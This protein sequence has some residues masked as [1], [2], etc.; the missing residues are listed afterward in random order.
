MYSHPLFNSSWGMG[1]KV[2]H[3][4]LRECLGVF[5]IYFI[6]FVVARLSHAGRTDINCCLVGSWFLSLLQDEHATTPALVVW[7]SPPEWVR[8]SGASSGGATKCGG[9]QSYKASARLCVTS[10]GPLSVWRS[11]SWKQYWWRN[12]TVVANSPY[13]GRG[14]DGWLPSVGPSL[15]L[16]FYFSVLSSCSEGRAIFKL[17]E[18]VYFVHVIFGFWSVASS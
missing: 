9:C 4:R 14:Q 13:I 1:R 5:V 17:G 16:I 3:V 2:W 6:L 7:A 10:C 18:G 12:A 8:H 11:G 15:S